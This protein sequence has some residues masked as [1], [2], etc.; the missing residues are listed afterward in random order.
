M[1]DD[2]ASVYQEG[3]R[4]VYR[5][6]ALGHCIRGLVA[7]RQGLE[8]QDHPDWL[9]RR[10]D[11][12]SKAEAGI[13]EHFTSNEWQGYRFKMLDPTDP[14]SYKDAPFLK[15]GMVDDTGQFLAEIPVGEHCIIRGHLDGIAQVYQ[16]PADNGGE[17]VNGQRVVVEVKKFGPDYWKKW[18]KDGIEGFPLY[19]T[20]LTDYME[21]AGLPGV[22]V[23]GRTEKDLET[24]DS[25]EPV[26]WDVV[27][28]YHAPG[29]LIDS[30]VRVLKIER[31]AQAGGMAECDM[32]DYP[33]QWYWT[34]GKCSEGREDKEGSPKTIILKAG[35]AL[36]AEFHQAI[37]NLNAASVKKNNAEEEKVQANLKL[38][39]LIMEAGEGYA[40]YVEANTNE[41]GEFGGLVSREKPVGAVRLP[42]GTSVVDTVYMNKGGT[43]EVKPYWVRYPKVNKPPKTQGG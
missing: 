6:S 12:G 27:F 42:D 8:P 26:E 30:K 20:Q 11:E 22:F 28:F 41:A 29:S 35:D 25:G 37:N 33:C 16:A 10:F 32:K 23:V 39:Q 17:W 13:I 34:G 24:G 15:P 9:L 43:R 31:L 38:T 19:V 5:V 18:K 1:G 36:V 3:D 40:K 21:A 4:W 14:Q 7:A 2:R